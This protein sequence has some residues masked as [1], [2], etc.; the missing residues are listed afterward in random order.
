MQYKILCMLRFLICLFTCFQFDSYSQEEIISTS[1]LCNYY[2]EEGTASIQFIPG[3][4]EAEQIITKIINVIGLK[5]HFEIRAANVPNAAAVIQNGKR[6]VLYDPKFISD[7]NKA[8]GSK[9]AAVSILAH[10]IGH[11]LNGHTLENTGS[12][13]E[14]ELE[15]DEFSG[16]V[17]RKLGS[18]LVE[19]QAAMKIAA[20]IKA[21]HTHPAKSDRLYAIARGWNNAAGQM[22]SDDN[23]ETKTNTTIEKPAVVRS[24]VEHTVLAEK[25]IAKDVTFLADPKGSYYVT[26]RGNLVKVEDEKLFIIGRLAESNRKQFPFMLYDNLY[27]Y[28]YIDLNGTIY[29]GSGKKVGMIREHS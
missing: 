22:A 2:G 19:A 5:P 16:F 6:Y 14:I 15:A 13:P 12:R 1:Q 18:T 25:Y 21:S 7:L 3:N 10:E 28:L 29:N 24:K 17:L 4:T 26:I 27:N 23:E 11:H 8:A 9:W 20:D